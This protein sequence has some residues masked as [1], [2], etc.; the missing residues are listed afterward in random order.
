[1]KFS[2]GLNSNREKEQKDI[3]D[4]REAS[5]FV[6]EMQALGLLNTETKESDE[7]EESY[8]DKLKKLGIELIIKDSGVIGLYVNYLEPLMEKLSGISKSSAD[9]NFT[10]KDKENLMSL[11]HFAFFDQIVEFYKNGDFNNNLILD[12]R[13]NST[14]LYKKLKEITGDNAD[15]Y[16]VGVYIKN[17][18]DAWGESDSVENSTKR[19]YLREL[20]G[21]YIEGLT[22]PALKDADMIRDFYHDLFYIRG[23]QEEVIEEKEINQCVSN[24]K[25]ELENQ[26]QVLKNLDIKYKDKEIV[27]NAFQNF[28]EILDVFIRVKSLITGRA[29]RRAYSEMLFDILDKFDSKINKFSLNDQFYIR[30][31][32]DVR[33]FMREANYR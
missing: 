10:D 32:E 22:F 11:I 14:Q 12:L 6:E 26:F 21:V 15:Q 30:L 3:E 18:N 7:L 28:T 33:A 16:A 5:T 27:K 19:G 24:P 2:E 8:R 4:I 17:F 29:L 13:N 9:K 25:E 23:G 31:Q 1:M 20:S